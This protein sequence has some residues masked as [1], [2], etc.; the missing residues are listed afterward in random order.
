VLFG[1]LNFDTTSVERAAS[2]LF[3]FV[4]A[5]EGKTTCTDAGKHALRGKSKSPEGQP[6]AGCSESID[7]LVYN[8]RQMQ[9]LHSEVRPLLLENQLLSDHYATIA[10]LQLPE[11]P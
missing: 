11:E 3:G 10:T 8:P 6:C 1:D 5:L 2:G 4:N 9:V 7:G